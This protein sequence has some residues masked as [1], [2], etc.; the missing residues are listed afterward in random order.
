MRIIGAALLLA[1]TL[2]PAVASANAVPV[3]YAFGDSLSDA[4]N[5][6]IGTGGATP[7]VP[8]YAAVNGFGVYSNGPVWVQDLSQAL[9][10]GTLRPSLAG[11]TDFAVGGASAGAF[12]SYTGSPGD[13]LPSAGN[14]LANSQIGMFDAAVPTPN[15]NALYTLSIGS[16]DLDYIFAHDAGNPVQASLDAQSVLAN[17]ATFV[18]ELA[19][20]GA[21][22]LVALN[23]PD[24]GKTP[25]GMAG[26]P[27]EAAAISSFVAGFDAAFGN[28]LE[29]EAELYG[30]DLHIIDSYALVDE[31]VADPAAFGLTNVT[32][33]CVVGVSVCATP[34]TYLFWDGHH[35]TETGQQLL[36]RTALQAIPEPGAA[37][38]LSGAVLLLGVLRRR[39]GMTL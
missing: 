2:I 15:P 3:I 19:A 34:D 20:D 36:A 14:P 24:L 18:G 33:P 10:L 16:N 11:G 29:A 25:D 37:G 12:G 5:A 22:N 6:Y 7:P 13:L 21:H 38:L 9:G 35:P 28:T 4:G 27:A 39:R 23:V 17:I 32:D 30:L 8:P 1:S 26:G 31:A